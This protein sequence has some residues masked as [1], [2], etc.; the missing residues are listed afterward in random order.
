MTTIH[1]ACV[2]ALEK[3]NTIQMR[4]SAIIVE[5]A[6]ILGRE[7]T[8]GFATQCYM[9]LGKSKKVKRIEDGFYALKNPTAKTVVTTN[10]GKQMQVNMPASV[11]VSEPPKVFKQ[12]EDVNS[13]IV[14]LDKDEREVLL[15][16]ENLQ[17]RL[18]LIRN[19]KRDYY[20]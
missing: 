11:K 7:N 14:N 15:Q 5:A 17:H 6:K 3:S 20:R 12:P 13:H 9:A 10:S 8:K 16:I 19:F 4:A 1:D 2:I 18:V